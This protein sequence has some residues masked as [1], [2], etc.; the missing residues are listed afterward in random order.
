MRRTMPAEIETL[1]FQAEARQLLHLVIH[2]IYSNKDIFLRELISNASHA[3]DK[4]RLASFAD[5]ELQV[6]ISNPKLEIA[7]NP[8]QRT[9]TVTDNGMAMSR[10][11]AGGVADTRRA[12]AGSGAAATPTRLR[13]TTAA[14]AARALIIQCGVGSYSCFMVA[15][16][17]SLV[18]RGAGETEATRCESDGQGAY[19]IGPAEAAP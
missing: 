5:K 12:T 19:T 6:D 9:L 2:S 1:E 18:T 17:V 14:A 4:L 8:E 13:E 7:V 3:L 11:E 16:R 15:H 10:P